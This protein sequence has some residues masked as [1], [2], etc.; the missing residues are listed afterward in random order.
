M[1]SEGRIFQRGAVF[2]IAYYVRGKEFR[3]A[4]GKTEKE[5]AK[6]LKARLGEKL[7]DRFIGP[8]QER[9]TV[10]DLLDSYL[11]YLEMKGAK[12]L[13]SVTSNVATVRS[14]FG[15]LRA[16]DVTTKRI[17]A[18]IELELATKTGKKK[19]KAA[20][21]VN[22][23]MA[24]LRGAF[25]L[26]RKQGRISRVPYFPMLRENN[27]RQGFF[28]KDEFEA[29]EAALPRVLADVARFAYL[30][31]WRKGEILPLTWENVDRA[32]AE[33][34]IATSKNG[35]GR[36]LP[37]TGALKG[38]IERR[39]QAREYLTPREGHRDFSAGIPRQRRA[40]R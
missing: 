37:L 27:A 10:G 20:A 7:G 25:N 2:W 16:V 26:A 17:E 36:M 34:R 8:E 35:H 9:V 40:C 23:D 39:W 21:T 12:S 33:V 28:E 4:G 3:E 13:Y 19:M 29:V 30:S 15:D 22:R 24:A 14:F 38:L 31:G 32:A 11:L 18:F 5:A 6:K 1:R